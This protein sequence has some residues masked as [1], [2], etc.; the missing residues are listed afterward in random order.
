MG[1]FKFIIIISVLRQFE[2]GFPMVPKSIQEEFSLVGYLRLIR[3]H[4]PHF[5]KLVKFLLPIPTYTDLQEIE[6]DKVVFNMSSHVLKIYPCPSPHSWIPG[7]NTSLVS[8]TV[9]LVFL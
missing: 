1:F 9:L 6:G 8:T 2:L 7:E 3:I 4:Y 5:Y